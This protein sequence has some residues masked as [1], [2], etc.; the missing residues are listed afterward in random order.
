MSNNSDTASTVN[1]YGVLQEGKVEILLHVSLDL[2]IWKKK[3]MISENR[4][5]TYA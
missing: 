1:Q 5:E 3:S 4:T 2:G